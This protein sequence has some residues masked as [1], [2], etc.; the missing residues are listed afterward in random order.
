MKEIVAVDFVML[1]RTTTSIPPRSSEENSWSVACCTFSMLEVRTLTPN[2][3]K[4]Q[5]SDTLNILGHNCN[6]QQEFVKQRTVA[7]HHFGF[8][9]LRSLFWANFINLTVI[10]R[11][12]DSNGWNVYVSTVVV[13]STF[14]T[15]KELA[16]SISVGFHKNSLIVACCTIGKFKSRILTPSRFKNQTNGNSNHVATIETINKV[17][18]NKKLLLSIIA[19]LT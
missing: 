13:L 17:F 1:L 15:A 18:L 10:T 2:R 5:S 7:L 11:Y 6:H 4:N 19:V 8:K 9:L 16:L 3:F 14:L 12:W